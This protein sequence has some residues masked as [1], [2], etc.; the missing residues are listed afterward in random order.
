MIRVKR[1]PH[2]KGKKKHTKNIK[3][4]NVQQR[5]NKENKT[6]LPNFRPIGLRQGIMKDKI[7]IHG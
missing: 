7:I 6:W 5:G 4:A 3:T 2:L 1:F